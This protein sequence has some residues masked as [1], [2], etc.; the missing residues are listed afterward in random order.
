VS[1]QS[2]GKALITG[3]SSGIGAVYADRLAKRGYDLIVVARNKERLEALAARLEQETGRKIEVVQ[4]DLT[5]RSGLARVE[6]ILD[7]DPAV[8]FLVNNAGIGVG[9]TI[10]E[11]DVEAL[12]R[13]VQLNATAPMRLA[14]AAAR[15][16]AARGAGTI[17]NIASVLALT[18]E[19]FNGVYSGTKAFLLNLSMSM[20]NELT[21][22]GVRVQAVLPGATRT[23][24]WERAGV[25]VDGF[26]PEMVMSVDEMVDAAL[27]G[28]DQGELITVPSLPDVK[29][30]NAFETARIALKPNLSRSHAAERYRSAHAA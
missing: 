1:I 12:D 15:G 17:V 27:S 26:P 21:G 5:Q 4:A 13:M 22:K 10:L 25:D 19:L 24:I 30:W 2:R 18:P 3:A 28:L 23:E 8:G 7:V 9:G 6:A 29:D 14:S 20:Q 16:M 11:A